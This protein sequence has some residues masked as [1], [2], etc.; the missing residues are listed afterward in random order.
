[1]PLADLDSL[2]EFPF[3]QSIQSEF[4]QKSCLESEKTSLTAHPRFFEI[5]SP[6]GESR[7]CSWIESIDETPQKTTVQKAEKSRDGS[8]CIKSEKSSQRPDMCQCEA[9]FALSILHAGAEDSKL[10]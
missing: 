6:L 3:G 9:V 7:L 10:H 2:M 8:F 5:F 4:F 1:M